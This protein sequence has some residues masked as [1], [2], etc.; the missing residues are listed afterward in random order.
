[1]S[2][3]MLEENSAQE[4]EVLGGLNFGALKIQSVGTDLF[5]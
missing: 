2:I 3:P 4:D 5:V 1:M